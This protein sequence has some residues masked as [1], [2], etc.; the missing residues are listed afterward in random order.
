MQ[1]RE[2]LLPPWWLFAVTLLIVPAAVLVFLPIS[3]GWGVAVAV[4]L[5]VASSTTLVLLSPV[6]EVADGVL[7]AGRAHIP[8]R[9]LGEPVAL[10]R[11][12]STIALR[13]GY[14]AG[15]YHCTVAWVPQLVRVPIDDPDDATTA[16]VVSSRDGAALAEAISTARRSAGAGS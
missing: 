16:W 11:E 10:D 2:R 4:V 7:T 15:A 1:H 8:V 13:T 14:D 3:P 12:A 6:V 9:L 5:V